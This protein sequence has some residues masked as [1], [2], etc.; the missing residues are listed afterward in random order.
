MI[1]CTN[2][3]Q[4]LYAIRVSMGAQA[5]YPAQIFPDKSGQAVSVDRQL[6][7]P[8]AALSGQSLTGLTTERCATY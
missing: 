3:Q 1:K 7:G 4:R 8:K 5:L 2:A 6:P